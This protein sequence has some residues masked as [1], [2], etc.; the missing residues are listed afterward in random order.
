MRSF[1]SA[2]DVTIWYHRPFKRM[3]QIHNVQYSEKHIKSSQ[4]QL[5]YEI[6]FT[7]TGEYYKY[8]C[9]YKICHISLDAHLLLYT[10]YMDVLISLFSPTIQKKNNLKIYKF[11]FDLL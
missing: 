8:L 3:K 4:R 1:Q 11:L 6:V 2:A 7:Y 10:I 5:F 9:V